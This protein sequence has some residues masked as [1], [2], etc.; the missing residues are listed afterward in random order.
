MNKLSISDL[1]DIYWL[2][3]TLPAITIN[4]ESS[5]ILSENTSWLG[6]GIYISHFCISWSESD[7]LSSLNTSGCAWI[8]DSSYQLNELFFWNSLHFFISKIQTKLFSRI[9]IPVIIWNPHLYIMFYCFIW[10]FWPLSVLTFRSF[11]FL[12]LAEKKA[13]KKCLQQFYLELHYNKSPLKDE[14][15]F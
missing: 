8:T 5:G 2:Q 3:L 13:R 10:K 9:S 12:S 7:S 6:W 14:V 11:P 4:A 1:L 15:H